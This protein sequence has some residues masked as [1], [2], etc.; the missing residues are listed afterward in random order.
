[1]KQNSGTSGIPRVKNDP[2]KLRQATKKRLPIPILTKCQINLACLKKSTKRNA[3][4]DIH[5]DDRANEDKKRPRILKDQVLQ[6]QN[7]FD[8]SE[9]K[10]EFIKARSKKAAKTSSPSVTETSSNSSLLNAEA[11]RASVDL[12]K[13]GKTSV[14]LKP[15]NS[16]TGQFVQ[17]THNTNKKN[18]PKIIS[19]PTPPI[20]KM[21]DGSGNSKVPKAVRLTQE[22]K[23]IITR[24][25]KTI[26]DLRRVVQDKQDLLADATRTYIDLQK[27][28]LN[29]FD[30]LFKLVSDLKQANPNTASPDSSYK[31]IR[32]INTENFTVHVGR[33]FYIPNNKWNYACPMVKPKY[34]V[35]ELARALIG[36]S[37]LENSTVTGDGT[38]RK[39]SCNMKEWD[40]VDPLKIEAI[41]ANE[42]NEESHETGENGDHK[43]TSIQDG[44]DQDGE[45]KQQETESEN[46][47]QSNGNDGTLEILGEQK[48]PCHERQIDGAGE[49][50]K[51]E[52][53]D[54]YS[55]EKLCEE[56]EVD[57]SDEDEQEESFVGENAGETKAIQEYRDDYHAD[58]DD[59]DRFSVSSTDETIYLSRSKNSQESEDIVG[60]PV[61][62]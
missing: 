4:Q 56:L 21:G 47:L 14:L 62:R 55:S 61:P 34:F 29:N 41:R 11:G 2:E 31:S 44:E 57:E 48:L 22:Q 58:L 42:L 36:D 23:L 38:H 27:K 60:T 49:A 35:Y 54:E 7:E 24:Q 25:Q 59:Y 33:D 53:T 26:E 51:V 13:M 39:G 37:V 9:V 30:E 12:L 6:G 28:T 15:A 5:I 45:G 40:A 17:N 50:S 10:Q 18:A 8:S 20:T 32:F 3:L 1:M 52:Q 46:V 43:P 16:G 19:P